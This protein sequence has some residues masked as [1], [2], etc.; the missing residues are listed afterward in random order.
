MSVAPRQLA[1]ALAHAE[2]F[3][4]EDFLSGPS[5]AVALALIDAWPG[6]PHRTVMLTGPEGS[7]KSHLAATWAQAAGARLICVT[8]ADITT[9][10][11]PLLSRAATVFANPAAAGYLETAPERRTPRPALAVPPNT[12]CRRRGTLRSAH[13]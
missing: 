1:L 7:G 12:A 6:W 3:A 4:R 5:N 10:S 9:S 11:N 8:R 13:G 2:S